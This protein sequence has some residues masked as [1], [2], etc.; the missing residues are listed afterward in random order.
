MKG[1]SAC[2]VCLHS[3][4]ACFEPV[5]ARSLSLTEKA[6]HLWF[7]QVHKMALPASPLSYLNEHQQREFH[8]VRNP[9]RK[10]VLVHIHACVNAVLS[11]YTGL[12][13]CQHVFER[14]E[15][16]KPFLKEPDDLHF[17]LS[18]SHHAFVLAVAR[19]SVGV[20][21]EHTDRKIPELPAIIQRYY[22][23]EEQMTVRDSV[24]PET[25]F[26]KI[27]TRKEA[28]IKAI[29][30]GLHENLQQ[31]NTLAAFNTPNELQSCWH[32]Y[33]GKMEEYFFSL[34]MAAEA[35]IIRFFH[36]SDI[37]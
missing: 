15:S 17:N 19:H 16:G 24:Q 25:E 5:P 26:L 36:A 29:G 31:I 10:Y 20:D 21:L 2:V 22:S 35:D 12:P 27:W 28:I 9:E 7:G 1:L 3:L 37:F 30:T 34:A 4:Q 33:S 18:H 6:V 11:L 23:L 8:S 13:A 32:V 14:N